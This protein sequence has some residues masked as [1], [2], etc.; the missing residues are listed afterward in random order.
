[1]SRGGGAVGPFRV[2]VTDHGFPNL[3][4]E[5]SIL[6][7]L[8]ATVVEPDAIYDVDCDIYAPCALGAT[9]NDTTIPR[10]KCKVVAGAA[11][12]QLLDEDLLSILHQGILEAVP[13]RYRLA[14]LPVP[15]AEVSIGAA[16]SCPVKRMM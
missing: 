5:R 14:S 16:R 1:M 11:N 4:G 7:P 12:N 6:E 2:V 13:I 3:D 15:T 9:L 8:G 10:L